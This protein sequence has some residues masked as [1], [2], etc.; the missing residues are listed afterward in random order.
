MASMIGSARDQ[1]TTGLGMEIVEELVCSRAQWADIHRDLLAGRHNFLATKLSAL[2]FRSRSSFVFYNQL[3]LLVSRHRQL[4]GNEL[5]VMNQQCKRRGLCE[6]RQGQQEPADNDG[7]NAHTY[8][9][10]WSADRD[11]ACDRGFPTYYQ[12]TPLLA[13]NSHY[14]ARVLV[15]STFAKK[16][17]K[18]Y[19]LHTWE[20][21]RWQCV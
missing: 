4:A 21:C 7:T 12:Y 3:D 8:R 17:F 11:E 5:I 13:I 14:Q 19:F 15:Q 20:Y 18:L 6:N 16:N 2:E 1:M 10:K 9:G